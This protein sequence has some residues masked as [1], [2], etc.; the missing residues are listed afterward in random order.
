MVGGGQAGLAVGY[1]LRRSGLSFAIFD[2]GEGPGGAW[3]HGWDSLTAFSPALHSSLPG[4]IMPGGPER[5]PSRDETVGYL[6]RYEERY[7]LLVYRPARVEEVRREGEHL[8]LRMRAVRVRAGAPA[9]RRRFPSASLP[10]TGD[11]ASSVPSF[12]LLCQER[13]NLRGA[14]S[15]QD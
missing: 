1:Y 12:N 10:P 14:L 5:Y 8:V 13:S 9:S 15:W 4:W 6:S 7:E 2:A 11:S 3:R